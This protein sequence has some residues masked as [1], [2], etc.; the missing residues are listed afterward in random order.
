MSEGSNFLADRIEADLAAGTYGGRVVTRFPPEPNGFLHI[1]HAKAIVVDFGLAA[2]YGGRCHLRF[3]D[4]NP[5]GEDTLFVEAIQRDVRWLGYDWGEHLYFASD[6]FEALY[7]FAERLIRAGRA[8]VCSLSLD[9]IRAT[10][11]TVTEP[12]TPSPDRERPVEESLRL[13]REMREGLHPE[14]AYTVR[15]KIDM[16][17]PNMKMRDPLMYRI[18]HAHHHRTGDAWHIYPMY[19]YAHGLSDAIEGITHSFCTLEFENNR[20]LYDWFVE[21]IFTPPVPRQHE[22]AR[23]ALEYVIVSKRHLRRLVLEGHVAGWD[24]PRM[25]TLAGLRRRGVPPEAIVAFVEKVGVSRADNLVEWSLFEHT[26]RDALNTTAP[27]RMAVLDPLRLVLDNVP[28]GEVRTFELD[29]WPH[30]VPREGRRP[31]PL[32]RDVFIERSDFAEDPPPGF[33]RLTPGGRVRLRGVGL[34]RCDRV[35]HAAD[36]SVERLVGALEPEGSPGPKVGGTIHWVSASAGE[37]ARVHLIDHLFT[38]PVPDEHPDGAFAAI[39]RES[40]VVV[41]GAVVEPAL[42]AAPAGTRVQLERLGYFVV[43]AERAADGRPVLVRTVPLKDSWGAKAQPAVAAPE[44]PAGKPRDGERKRV[45]KGASEALAALI[46]ARPEVG[47]RIEALADAGLSDDDAAVIGA[48]DALSG[49]FDG[50]VAA[51]ADA[52][53]VA[54]WLVN[55]V[56]AI[57]KERDLA[58]SGLTGAHLAELVRLVATDEITTAVARRVLPRVVEGAGSPSE[59]VDAEGLRPIRDEARIRAWA[60]EALAGA[61]DKVAA[62]RGGRTSLRGFFVGQVLRASGGRADPELVGRIVDVALAG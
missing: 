54:T 40:L 13:M 25:P 55:D 36:G 16:A 10:R 29:E 3:D 4:T 1:G 23:L 32:T 38:L 60:A 9:E 61:P 6:Y 11:G 42:A 48:E 62:Y 56:R 35:V 50:A 52:A 45:R 7:D 47:A 37:S 59:V 21:A 57:G 44:P 26:I 2:R 14:G 17:H 31:V 15:A 20:A 43:D 39:N 41:D 18:R 22:M 19:D 58:A 5:L 27:R 24:D 49:L 28:D 8:Y 46:A 51:G 34:F 30:D 12:G 53:A 33:K